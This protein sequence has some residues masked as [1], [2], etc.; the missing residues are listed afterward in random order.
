MKQQSSRISKR[1]LLVTT[2][3]LV[4]ICVFSVFLAWSY[5]QRDYI[6]DGVDR[7]HVEQ[8]MNE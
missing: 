8:Q 7:P 1:R 6:V 3:L 4:F 5:D 2:I